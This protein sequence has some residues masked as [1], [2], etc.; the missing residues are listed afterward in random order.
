[1][2][3]KLIGV[4]LIIAAFVVEIS[5][6]ALCFGSVIVG[7]VLLIFAPGILLAP[8]N[9][10]FALGL[11]F[12]AKG[13]LSDSDYYSYRSYGGYGSYS[14]SGSGYDSYSR[15]REAP[16]YD[17]GY[18]QMKRYYD[19]L[20]CSMDD[21]FETIRRAYKDLSRKYHP[22]AIEG[23]GL[24]REFVELATQKMQEINEAYAKIKEER[25]R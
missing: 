12:L 23:K 18:S 24:S 8:F 20:G 2:L 5:W 4:A 7:I 3:N 14:Q 22:D 15:Q 25:G 1:M 21:D 16:S 9:I 13:S 11:A 6:I 19:V 10:L 17:S